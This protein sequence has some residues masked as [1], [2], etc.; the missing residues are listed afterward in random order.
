MTVDLAITG[1]RIVDQGQSREGDLL[2]ADGVIVGVGAPGSAPS[3]TGEIIDAAGHLVI[4]GMIDVHVHTREPGWTHKEDITT[5]S[6]AAAAGGVTTI[7]GMPNLRPP[8]TTVETLREVLDLYAAKSVVDYNHNPAAS[9]PDQ[10]AGMAELGIAAYKIYMVV[11]TGREYPHP[12]GTGMHDHG[13]LL[14]MFETI[15]PTGLPFMV[16]PHD[17]GIMDLIEQRYWAAGDRSPEAYAKTLAAYD[18]VIWDTAIGVLLR[19]AEATECPLH[20]VHAQTSRSIE[21][22]RQ[23]KERGLR[24]SAEANH[25]TLF[26]GSWDDVTTL[27]PY[28]LSYW[29]PDHHKEATW[30]AL[31]DGTIDMANS[32][33]APHTREEKE[34][35]WT[36]MWAAH[37]GTPGIQYQLPLLVDA[38]GKGQ[39]SIERMVEVTSNAPAR[40]FGL[41]QK[42]SFVPG[43]DA[44]VTVIDPDLEWT[45]TDEDVLSRI[46]WTPYAGRTIR[47]KVIRTLIR[48][49]DVYRDGTVVG[50]PGFGKQARPTTRPESGA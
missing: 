13:H 8:T 18:G 44:D 21:M 41:G 45:I 3:D 37:T 26:L 17:Q 47:G 11:D 1:G 27:G 24:V 12:A 9:N 23:A 38:V 31:V 22:I 33:H 2:I 32:D 40:I 30:E 14:E 16:H 5:C 34:V 28:A 10:I 49:R 29:V 43:V 42:G 36:D 25:W 7:F 39:M 15:A 35:G 4:P 50:A 46:G 20:I 19:I 6:Q 48:G